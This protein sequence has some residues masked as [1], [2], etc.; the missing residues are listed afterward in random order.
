MY[1]GGMGSRD[2]NFYNALAC[3]MGFE[4][5]AKRVQDLFL[6]RRHREAAAAVPYDFIDQTSLIGPPARVAERLKEF[7]DAGVTTLNV[8]PFGAD[9]DIRKRTLKQ[10][11]AALE[12]AGL[13]D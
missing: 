7:A 12:L 2:Q 11:S 8:S 10:V 9:A 6:D 3:R 13:A 5:E 1:I 4:A